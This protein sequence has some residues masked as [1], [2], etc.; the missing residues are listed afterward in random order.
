MVGPL[1]FSTPFA[2]TGRR[3]ADVAEE[4]GRSTARR[5]ARDTFIAPNAAHNLR[6]PAWVGNQPGRIPTR[7]TTGR[8]AAPIPGWEALN[9]GEKEASDRGFDD[10]DAPQIEFCGP[11]IENKTPCDETDPWPIYV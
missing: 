4:S 3:F 1:I 2:R 11:C 10:R 8:W 7:L 5:P 9:E 6:I